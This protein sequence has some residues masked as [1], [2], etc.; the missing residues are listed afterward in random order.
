MIDPTFAL[1]FQLLFLVAYVPA[2]YIAYRSVRV[3]LKR[4]RLRRA[5]Q[6]LGVNDTQQIDATVANAFQ[7][8]QYEGI[9]AIRD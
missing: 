3:P 7:F 6:Q 1:I 2:T 9:A 8:K 4:D 5:L